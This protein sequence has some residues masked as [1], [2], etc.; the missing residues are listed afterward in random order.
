MTGFAGKFTNEQL[1]TQIGAIGP[2]ELQQ[3]AKLDQFLQ[4]MA[5]SEAAKQKLETILEP[6]R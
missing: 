3:Y 5:S 6:Q 4:D 2:N 1:R